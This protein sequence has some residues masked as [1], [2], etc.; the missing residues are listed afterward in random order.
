LRRPS[1]LRRAIFSCFSSSV[2]QL[3][4][5]P[6][7][8]FNLL[9]DHHDDPGP[10]HR[11]VTRMAEAREP[12]AQPIPEP[13][14]HLT[15]LNTV[16]GV[17]I[18]MGNGCECAVSPASFSDHLRRKH[19]TSLELR[20][21]VDR[22]IAGFPFA[23]DYSSVPLPT[24]GLAPQPIIRIVEGL[25]CRHCRVEE[26]PPFK[27]QSWDVLKSIEIRPM[28]RRWLWTRICLTGSSSSPGFG[29]EGA[30]LGCGR[31]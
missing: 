23:Y 14:G 2:T 21:Q 18:C 27:T 19:E 20:Q 24:D 7:P 16:Y 11:T 17:L 31:E 26:Q 22:Y 29:K 30:V 15:R 3:L 9:P 4:C 5:R 28:V 12:Q 10:I 6:R 1:R 8:T 25:R 13:L